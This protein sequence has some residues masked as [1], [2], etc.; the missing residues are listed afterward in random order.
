MMR[1]AVL[2]L[3][4]CAGQATAQD[5]A[6]RSDVDQLVAEFEIAVSQ[7]RIVSDTQRYEHP[8][9]LRRLARSLDLS[10][11]DYQLTENSGYRQIIQ[12]TDIVGF[13][14]D[15]GAI[16]FGR[17]GGEDWAIAP[18]AIQLQNTGQAAFPLSCN[19]LVIFDDR[20]TTYVTTINGDRSLAIATSTIPVIGEMMAASGTG[21]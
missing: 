6:W 3:A 13:S 15:R 17:S 21:C 10:V 9:I 20:G 2:I 7:E 14:L 18:Y 19:R 1:F 8:A 5:A 11:V 16:T 4:F 12:E